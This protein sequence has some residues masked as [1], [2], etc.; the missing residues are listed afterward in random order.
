VAATS[1]GALNRNY[2]VTVIKEAVAA[3]DDEARDN[4]LKR[5]K[6]KGAVVTSLSQWLESVRKVK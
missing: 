1:Q 3:V 5:L 2:R 4:A 6:E